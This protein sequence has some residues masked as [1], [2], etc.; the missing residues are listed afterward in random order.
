[1]LV[2]ALTLVLA[3]VGC[4]TTTIRD[5]VL[6]SSGFT[7]KVVEQDGTN[8]LTITGYKG[9]TDVIIPEEINGMK[10]TAIDNRA[11]RAPG[12]AYEYR[13]QQ[14]TSV[15]IPN[16][17]TFIGDNA[18]ANNR[19]TSVVIPDSVTKMGSTVFQHNN[20]TNIT[21][22]KNLI[23]IGS[24]PFGD[25]PIAP[26]YYLFGKSGTYIMRGRTCTLDGVNLEFSVITEGF[27]VGILSIDGESG[28][29]FSEDYDTYYVLPGLHTF[30]LECDARGVSGLWYFGSITYETATGKSYTVTA[31]PLKEE[32][33]IR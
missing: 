16:T 17:V 30:E 32:F 25:N 19:L 13:K 8:T 27:A 23:S 21:I 5:G 9:K 26:I 15:I 3:V 12:T 22:S 10:V 1:M 20:L 31:D 24:N 18:F 7:A 2:M 4:A 14:L 33:S 28:S 29:L 6:K 11:F